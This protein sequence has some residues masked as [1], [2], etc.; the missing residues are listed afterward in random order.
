[1][2]NLLNKNES[3]E[4]DN[5]AHSVASIV[6]KIV[7]FPYSVRLSPTETAMWEVFSD[8]QHY[9][10]ALKDKYGP[11]FDL[12]SA[13]NRRIQK[14]IGMN[15]ELSRSIDQIRYERSGIVQFESTIMVDLA[16]S[17]EN[18]DFNMPDKSIQELDDPKNWQKWK[19]KMP[20]TVTMLEKCHDVAKEVSVKSGVEII[21]RRNGSPKV[22]D[23]FGFETSFDSSNMTQEQ[24]LKEIERRCKAMVK[25][26]KKY[27]PWLT[28]SKYKKLIQ[29]TKKAKT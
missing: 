29:S 15:F 28:G 8:D 5:M 17:I 9:Y 27:E 16:W 26:Y 20:V 23:E 19:R 13:S 22:D 24:F 4:I 11:G 3:Q 21:V 25:A 18:D 7:G 1:M 14:E 6:T 2:N 12:A 10:R